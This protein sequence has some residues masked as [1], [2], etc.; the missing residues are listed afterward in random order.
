MITWQDEQWELYEWPE[1]PAELASPTLLHK[2]SGIWVAVVGSTIAMEF[3]PRRPA[4]AIGIDALSQL[5]AAASRFEARKLEVHGVGP[6]TEVP[7]PE[8]TVALGDGNES[9]KRGWDLGQN[10]AER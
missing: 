7:A 2:R 4:M 5:L 1:L 6:G 8:P 3:Q 10:G 9:P